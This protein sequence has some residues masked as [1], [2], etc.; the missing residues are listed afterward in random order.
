MSKVIKLFDSEQDKLVEHVEELLQAVKRGEFKNIAIA[1]E[2]VDGTVVTGYCNA[3]AY[4]RQVLVSHMQLDIVW[5][6]VRI[7][8][9]L[10]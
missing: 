10:L 2:H 4:D 1:A 9:D 7:N 3:D 8:V 6:M 5:N